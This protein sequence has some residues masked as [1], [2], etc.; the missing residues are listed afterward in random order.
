MGAERVRQL[1]TEPYNRVI[2]AA[3]ELRVTASWLPTPEYFQ[4]ERE[5]MLDGMVDEYDEARPYSGF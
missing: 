2:G 4:P 1:R 3:G 5:A